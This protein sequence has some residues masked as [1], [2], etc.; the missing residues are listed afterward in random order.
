MN[1]ISLYLLPGLAALCLMIGWWRRV[2]IY[3][4]FVKGAKEG[5]KTAVQILPCL[6]AMLTAIGLMT[7][8]GI[9]KMVEKLLAPVFAAI[10]ILPET[11][12]LMLLRPLSG[13][14][15]LAMLQDIFSKYGPDSQ[16]G[17]LASTLMGSSETIFYTVGLY[18]ST[19]GVKKSRYAIPAALGA[20]L[21]G[22]VAAGWFYR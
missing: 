6:I 10:G 21:A 22:S 2:P 15:S 9:L 1:G 5:L 13:S 12:P 3:D 20:W 16:A 19:A 14:A 11:A 4:A 8:S 17:L 18:L 7:G